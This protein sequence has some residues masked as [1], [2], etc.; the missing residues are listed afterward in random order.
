MRILAALM[1]AGLCVLARAQARRDPLT[2]RE[3]N[4]MRENAQDPAKR[5]N[6]LLGFARERLLAIERLHGKPKP[7][8]PTPAKSP[9]CWLNWPP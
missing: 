7:S 1:V 5:I 8:V 2:A 6:L 3:V 9:I 4:Q